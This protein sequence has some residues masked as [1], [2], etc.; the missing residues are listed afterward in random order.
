MPTVWPFSGYVVAPERVHDVVAPAYDALTPAQRHRYAGSHPDNYVNAMRSL[1]EFPPQ[2]RPSLDELLE[3]NKRNL[4]ALFSQGAFRETASPSLFIYRLRVDDHEQVGLVGEVPVEEYD[5]NVIKKHEHTQTSREDHL[6][7]YNDVVGAAS[8]PVCLSYAHH[9]EVNRIIAAHMEQAP[10]IDFVADDGVAQSV[11]CVTDVDAQRALHRCFAEV[12]EAYLTDGH[13][14]AAAGSRFARMRR[15]ANPDHTGNEP[16]NYLLVILFPDDQMRILPYN[17]HVLDL[18]GY[19][20]E[21]LVEALRGRFTVESLGPVPPEAAEPRQ[22][23]E[24]AML[25]EGDW[26]RLNV[27]PDTVPEDD[28]VDTL[29][30]SVLHDRV[31]E[32]LLGVADLRT[33]ERCDSVAGVLGMA[34]LAERC[35]ESG[36]V[37]F[38]CHPVSIHQLMAVADA[39]R[40]M[41]PKS[42]WFD[43]KVRSGIFLRLR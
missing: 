7:R 22:P 6:A 12:G 8:S 39:G 15:E 43:P 3:R 31:L 19:S 10:Y 11:W 13:H 9:P 5:R 29:D 38:A 27:D 4:N 20:A 21:E 40:V 14:R 23:R 35:R 16:Y 33:D 37:A 25:L 18:N 32:P 26:Y 41:P 24:F 42:T 28:P 36:G 2:E 34:G 1:E 30:I 17:R